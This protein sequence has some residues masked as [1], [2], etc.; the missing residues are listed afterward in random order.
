MY[1]FYKETTIPFFQSFFS[2]ER[3]VQNDL[4]AFTDIY[5]A[6]IEQNNGT[7]GNFCFPSENIENINQFHVFSHR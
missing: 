3:N 2:V 6:G 7:I 4:F 5:P 1:V